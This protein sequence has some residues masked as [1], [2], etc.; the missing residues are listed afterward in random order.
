MPSHYADLYYFVFKTKF[1]V[2]AVALS[3]L[4]VALPSMED[5]RKSSMEDGR[6]AG[7]N[8]R[9]LVEAESETAADHADRT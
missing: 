7:T 1:I 8:T 2:I 3:D 9:G 5:L 6:S 4:F